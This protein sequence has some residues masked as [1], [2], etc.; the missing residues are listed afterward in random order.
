MSEPPLLVDEDRH[1]TRAQ[2]G[3]T[4]RNHDP[5]TW[6]YHVLIWATSE[7]SNQSGDCQ[8]TPCFIG[9]PGIG[10]RWAV[11]LETLTRN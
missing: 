9:F 8:E 11:T 2:S 7:V 3:A 4:N 1:G 6:D 10:D 5:A